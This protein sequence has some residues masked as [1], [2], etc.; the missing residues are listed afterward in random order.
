M[1]AD[2]QWYHKSHIFPYITLYAFLYGLS[3]GINFLELLFD[4]F[5]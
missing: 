3:V 2:K 5:H 1:M 4:T